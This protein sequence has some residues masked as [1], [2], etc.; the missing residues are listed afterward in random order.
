[1]NWLVGILFPPNLELEDSRTWAKVKIAWQLRF[2]L[3]TRSPV[4]PFHRIGIYVRGVI[5]YDE[6]LRGMSDSGPRASCGYSQS[7]NTE[8][9]EVATQEIEGLIVRR[10]VGVSIVFV[11]TS[12]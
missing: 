12:R 10:Y 5:Y 8:Y 2:P 3:W 9:L 4:S 11:E 1:M 7:D 6:P